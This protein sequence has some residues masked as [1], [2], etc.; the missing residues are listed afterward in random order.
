MDYREKLEMILRWA[1][2]HSGFDISFVQSV[3]E[4]ICRGNELSFIQEMSIDKIIRCFHIE[5]QN[6]SKKIISL[7]EENENTKVVSL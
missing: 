7:F 2:S 1:P 3:Y 4:Q 6:D 5:K